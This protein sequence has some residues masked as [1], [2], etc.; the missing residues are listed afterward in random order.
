L[1]FIGVARLMRFISQCVMTGFVYSLA[2][3]IFIANLPGLIDVPW[4]LYLLFVL[5]LVFI[6]FWLKF[7]VT[8]PGLVVVIL[9]LTFMEMIFTINVPTVADKGE[10]PNELPIFAL[11]DVP[12]TI[13]TLR[14]ILPAALAMA[15]V[16][17]LESL[18]TA[19]LVDNITDTTS[20]K[21]REAIGQGTSNVLAALFGGMGGCAMIGQTM[22]NVR[23]SGARTRISTFVAGL[24]LMFLAVG[25]GDVVGMMPMAV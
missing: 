10:L 21:T 24:F 1:G 3:C 7:A 6:F 17:L 11:P 8:I 5:G 23:A 16:G 25:L 18:M 19:Q 9:V 4:A 14:I 12:L 15:V 2:I 22:I 13:D 20:S